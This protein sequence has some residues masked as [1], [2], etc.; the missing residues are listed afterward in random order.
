[1]FEQNWVKKYGSWAVITGASDGIGK[2]TAILLAEIGINLVLVARRRP[3]LEA[4][5][6]HLTTHFNIQCQVVALDL[7]SQDAIETLITETQ[8]LDIG[9]LVAAAG[10]GTS[11]SFIDLPIER[12]TNMLD[13]NCRAVLTLSHHFGKRFA[14]QGRGGIVLFSSLVAFQGVP[15]SAN[16]AATKAYIQSLVEGLHQELSPLGVDVLASA[17]GPIHSGFAVRANMQM[18]MALKADVVARET[19]RALGHKTTVQPGLLSKVMIGSLSFLPR[20]LRVRVMGQ[21]MGSMTINQPVSM[22]DIS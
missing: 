4:L 20:P 11:G 10:Y 1:M 22:I 9:L 16:Y 6:D 19:L 14:K 3:M 2:E 15:L 13:V 21:I 17:P 7:S 5:S 18:G 8:D 12:E